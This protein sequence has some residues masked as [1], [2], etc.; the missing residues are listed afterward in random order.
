MHGFLSDLSS[1]ARTVVRNAGFSAL[2]IGILALG[3]GANTAVF[4][5]V[6]SVLLA[7]LPFPHAERMARI[8]TNY[9]SGEDASQV[10][11]AP[12]YFH[13]LR[14]RS[15]LIQDIAAQRYHNMTVTGGDGAERV[16]GIGVSDGWMETVGQTPA[17]GRDFDAREQAAGR[18]SGVAIISHDLWQGR[19]RGREDVLGRSI[20]LDE[21]PFTIVGVMPAR[22]R[23]PYEADLWLPMR[24]SRSLATPSTLN[25]PVRLKP[26]ATLAQFQR[27]LE[28]ISAQLAE[29]DPE[30]DD[31]RLASRPFSEEFDR[32]PDGSILAL[33]V[34]VGL[35]LLIA[36]VN[37]ANL[38]LTRS[39]RRMREIAIRQ[40]IG[41]SR[42]RQIRQLFLE[43]LLLALVAAGLG[44]GL[45]W[46]LNDILTMLISNRLDEVVQEVQPD[47]GVLSAALG[48][49][50]FTAV[51]FALL[52]GLRATRISPAKTL[53]SGGRSAGPRAGAT[54]RGLVVAQVALAMALMVGAAVV[55]Q[56]LARLL[57]VDV[58]YDP[59]QITRISLGF[60]QPRFED[61]ER[62]ASA[63]AAVVERV[64]AVPGVAGAGITTLHP[65]PYQSGNTIAR[66]ATDATDRSRNLPTV[67]VRLVT[68]SYFEALGQNLLNG[69]LFTGRDS[70]DSE[71]RAVVNE[72]LAERFWPDGGAVG[73]QLYQQT[74]QGERANTVMGVV[75]DIA[76]PHPEQP[77]SLYLPY[78]QATRL[79]SPDSWSTQT[80]TLVVRTA[81]DIT[82][83]IDNVRRAVLEVEPDFAVFDI[84]PMDRVL[85]QP[86]ASQRMGTFVSIGFAAFALFMAVLGLYGVLTLNV[87][88][89]VPEFGIRMALGLG[90]AGLTRLV[91]N[92][93]L[94]LVLVGLAVGT[95]L[96]VALGRSLGAF[97]Q[98]VDANDPAV[99]VLVAAVLLAFGCLASLVPA[100]RARRLHPMDALRHE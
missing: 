71:A 94:R 72:S 57:N 28:A 9:G 4:S 25:V 39:S 84:E 74:R 62:R 91:V 11:V 5:V 44:F 40:T 83:I 99:Y 29:T 86:L 53:R 34:S 51:L 81:G 48:M 82:G 97:L 3:I 33:L 22:F 17:I 55:T 1:A 18:D 41:A 56:N 65:V 10:S 75:S 64:E 89:R 36:T 54:L 67:N 90:P 12:R 45:A 30:F 85:L 32:D 13:E 78:S 7:P 31:R 24:F 70:A 76:E 58:G 77:S 52:P 49:A 60:P 26:G 2:V 61:P 96:A 79:Q 38:M 88:Q 19:Y 87:Q 42:V 95:L 47:A 6:S 69:R 92:G 37:V 68:A 50:V 14:E 80:V 35:V 8:V 98:E 20:E 46:L 100:M 63:V 93:G 16:V 73:S 21:R 23:Y 27:E 15:R 59:A 43:G 66:V